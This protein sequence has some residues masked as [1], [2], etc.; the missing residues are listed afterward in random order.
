[1]KLL[2]LALLAALLAGCA[3]PS[4]PA[5]RLQATAAPSPGAPLA[6]LYFT[7]DGRFAAAPPASESTVTMTDPIN[8]P[9][10]STYPS[11][12]GAL[13]AGGNATEAT[14][15]LFVTSNTASLEANAVPVFLF[16]PGFDVD[17]ALGARNASASPKGPTLIHAGEVQEVVVPLKLNGTGPLRA[18]DPASV[19]IV[20][21][22]THV[23]GV[24]EFRYVLGPQHP[25]RIEFGGPQG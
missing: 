4:A 12:R 18:G 15:H 23:A 24:A 21:Y 11:W 17:V 19:E 22:Y 13:P 6:A 14:L 25:M 7:P 16:L 9:L 3:V 10:S 8:S 1:V 20:V 2:P 5:A